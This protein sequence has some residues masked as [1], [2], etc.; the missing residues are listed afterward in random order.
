MFIIDFCLS[1]RYKLIIS[2][3]RNVDESI[4][5][6]LKIMIEELEKD[7]LVNL[8]LE[9]N[10]FL[11]DMIV[12]FTKFSKGGE[13]IYNYKLVNNHVLSK[14]F[15]DDYIVK[16]LY[17]IGLVNFKLDGVNEVVIQINNV[18]HIKHKIL[19]SILKR[20]LHE[21]KNSLNNIILY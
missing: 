15:K 1:S 17:K 21:A 16:I 2:Y 11:E 5:K 9:L 13:I 3:L 20:F 10:I 6:I 8:L 4:Y 14:I 19:K 7:T 12:Y 18:L